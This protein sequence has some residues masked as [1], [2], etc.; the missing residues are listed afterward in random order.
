MGLMAADEDFMPGNALATHPLRLGDHPVKLVNQRGGFGRA[1][2]R[3][4]CP[5]VPE[6][7][8]LAALESAPWCL[9]LD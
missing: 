7:A 1:I 4:Q 9:G 8:F 5:I 2:G 6:D 3:D